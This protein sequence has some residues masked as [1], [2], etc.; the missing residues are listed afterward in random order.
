MDSTLFESLD[1]ALGVVQRF[2][3]PDS[4][5]YHILLPDLIDS[6]TFIVWS[7][8]IDNLVRVAFD[9]V[10]SDIDSGKGDLGFMEGDTRLDVSNVRPL[11]DS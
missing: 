9:I 10:G 2:R 8:D 11:G 1:N 6:S 3:Q 4:L 7:L 5:L